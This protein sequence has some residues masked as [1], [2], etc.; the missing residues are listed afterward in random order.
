[1]TVIIESERTYFFFRLTLRLF[2][3]LKLIILMIVLQGEYGG[4]RDD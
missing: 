1:M 4:D 2:L 3:F